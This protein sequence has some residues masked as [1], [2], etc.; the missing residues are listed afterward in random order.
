[1]TKRNG[2]SSISISVAVSGW[3]S[4]LLT[5]SNANFYLHQT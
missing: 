3:L 4:G 2:D 1:M 5:I